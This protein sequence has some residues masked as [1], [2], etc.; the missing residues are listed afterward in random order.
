VVTIDGTR[1]V[2][3]DGVLPD[4]AEQAPAATPPE[5]ARLLRWRSAGAGGCPPSIRSSE[6]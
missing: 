3:Y 4:E 5:L 6:S 2:V 1:G